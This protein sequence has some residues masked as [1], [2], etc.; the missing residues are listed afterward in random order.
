MAG[1][2]PLEGPVAVELRFYRRT[3]HRADGDNLEKSALDAMNGIVFL[4]DAQVVECHRYKA[5]DRER[6]RVEV[7]VWERG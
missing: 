1:R 5:L 6:P 2:A 7:R 4:D 3:A